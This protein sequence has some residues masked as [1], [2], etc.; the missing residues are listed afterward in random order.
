L[1]ASVY[2]SYRPAERLERFLGQVGLGIF[3]RLSAFI[4]IC[5]GV[6]IMWN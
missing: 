2:I 6:Q 3:L 5:I 1:R 4:V